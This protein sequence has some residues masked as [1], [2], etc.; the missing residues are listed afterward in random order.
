L[1]ISLGVVSYKYTTPTTTVS[2]SG[3]PLESIVRLGDQP[4]QLAVPDETLQ[5]G[6]GGMVSSPN[7]GVPE[8]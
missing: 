1:E 8:E 3:C 4:D 5:R 7:A 2:L 6:S